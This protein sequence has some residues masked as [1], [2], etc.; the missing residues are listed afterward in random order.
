MG[1]NNG[2]IS[3]IILTGTILVAVVLTGN[4]PLSGAG[5]FRNDIFSTRGTF[6]YPATEMKGIINYGYGGEISC[7]LRDFF[8]MNFNIGLIA[9]YGR[10]PGAIKRVDVMDHFPGLITMGY[11][12][13][14]AGP[15]SLELFGGGGGAY[16]MISYAENDDELN[17]EGFTKKAAFQ[18]MAR[19]G[20]MF[21]INLGSSYLMQIG[22]SYNGIFEK[23]NN[24]IID[25]VNVTA[26]IGFRIG[27][28]YPIEKLD[29][30]SRVTVE[31]M[32][33][34]TLTVIME[35]LEFVANKHDLTDEIKGELDR[36]AEVLKQY[37][38]NRITI[39]GHAASVG[40]PRGEMDTSIKRARTVKNYLVNKFGF[41]PGL[42]T[43][44]GMGSAKPV[45]DNSTEEGKASNR[46]V[47]IIVHGK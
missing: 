29:D 1:K 36:V 19:G 32:R 11:R 44:V 27:D 34:I 5:F 13:H 21:N 7:M 37:R 31:R 33:N 22:A 6:Y 4:E 26:G 47:E 39:E 28:G 40:K 45:G 30:M 10:F 14:M 20:G 42:L 25:F 18:G 9:G 15:V 41:K 38:N 35:Q 16:N 2:F 46:R 23:K 12:I 43:T 8:F 17:R 24:R 3:R